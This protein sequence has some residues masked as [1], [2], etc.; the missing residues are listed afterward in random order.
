MDDNRIVSGGFDTFVHVWDKE[1]A[2][3][4][5]AYRG[6]RSPIVAVKLDGNLIASSEWG[7]SLL[8]DIR[9]SRVVRTL[10]DEHGGIKCIDFS[11]G[12]LA[13]GGSGGDLTLWDVSR[14]VGETISAHDDDILHL[15]LAGRAVITSGG[16]H[17]IRMWDATAM[18]SLGVFHDSH[19]FETKSFRMEDRVFLAGQGHF[20]RIWRK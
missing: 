10:R 16:D 20:T 1:T 18:R 6:H 19:P 17:K 9:S 15:Q 8:W 13:C 11:D 12:I 7:W 14:N 4:V 5:S 2:R 3:Q